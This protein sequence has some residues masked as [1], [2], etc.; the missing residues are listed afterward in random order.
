MVDEKKIL[1]YLIEIKEKPFK[2]GENDCYTFGMGIIDRLVE[3]NPLTR[4]EYKN[5]KEALE[6][7]SNNSWIEEIKKKMNYEQLQTIEPNSFFI[8]KLHGFE[9]MH[10]TLDGRLVYSIPENRKLTATH[11]TVINFLY[12]RYGWKVRIK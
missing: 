11:I 7:A 5:K 3:E 8:C 6:I 2:W 1:D 12:P 10:Y 9:C 4:F